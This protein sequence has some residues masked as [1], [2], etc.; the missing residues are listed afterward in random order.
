MLKADKL[1]FRFVAHPEVFKNSLNLI[2]GTKKGVKILNFINF[3]EKKGEKLLI[4]LVI[5]QI[6][7]LTIVH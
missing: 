7:P 5:S 1:L 4:P 2:F 6:K 3:G